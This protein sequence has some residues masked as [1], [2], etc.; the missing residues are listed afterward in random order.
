MARIRNRAAFGVACL[1]GFGWIQSSLAQPTDAA[2][3]A[4]EASRLLHTIAVFQPKDAFDAPPDTQPLN[5]RKFRFEWRLNDG[6]QRRRGGSE[7]GFWTYDVDAQTLAVRSGSLTKTLTG[8]GNAFV[9][10]FA[11]LPLETQGTYKGQ[12]AY[13]AATTVTKE[14]LT[15]YA[16][17]QIIPSRVPLSTE[18]TATLKLP[19]QQARE[20]AQNL[21]LVVEGTVKPYSGNRA[22]YCQRER[23]PPTVDAPT[24]ITLLSCGLTAEFSRVAFERADTHEVLAARV[25]GPAYGWSPPAHAPP[26]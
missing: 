1:A 8:V 9:L 2:V 13:G 24:D 25:M 10:T 11:V 12:N 15:E 16:V 17:A 21:V 6:N 26:K 7:T 22:A 18:L 14:Q 5:G 23:V 3:S 20:A 19:P 4:A